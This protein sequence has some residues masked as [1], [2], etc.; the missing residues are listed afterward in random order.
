MKIEKH[1]IIIAKITESLKNLSEL[2]HTYI[3]HGVDGVR[4]SR[5]VNSTI[6]ELVELN[7][8]V[9]IISKE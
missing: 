5:I 2:M 4:F 6:I 3:Y 8:A 9:N 1:D 7:T